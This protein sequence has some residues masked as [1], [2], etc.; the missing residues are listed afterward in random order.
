MSTLHS[1]PPTTTAGHHSHPVGFNDQAFFDPFFPSSPKDEQ[2]IPT[3]NDDSPYQQSYSN[4][5]PSPPQLLNSVNGA[6]CNQFSL[7]QNYSVPQPSSE[8]AHT[9]HFQPAHPPQSDVDHEGASVAFDLLSPSAYL[10]E[11]G[12]STASEFTA[13]PDLGT[14]SFFLENEYGVLEAPGHGI[15]L[16]NPSSLLN[17]HHRGDVTDKL[18]KRLEYSQHPRSTGGTAKFSSHLMSPVLTE[19]GGSSSRCGTNSP[20]E[21]VNCVKTEIQEDGT[22]DSSM[23]DAHLRGTD[24]SGGTMQ[25]TPAFTEGS[26]GTSSASSSVAPTLARAPS[27]IIRVD[28]YSR[29]DS[30]A[31]GVA[32]LPR[33]GGKRSRAGSHTSH[34]TVHQDDAS[35]EEEDGANHPDGAQGSTIRPSNR[36]GLDP[37]ARSQINDKEIPSLKDQ[38][39]HEQVFLKTIDVVEWLNRSTPGGENIAN[40]PPP[41][42]AAKSKRQRAKSTGAQTL[43]HAN[44]ESFE[45][46]KADSHIPGPGVLINEESGGE[47]D[48]D[49][50]DLASIEDSPP[51][52]TALGEAMNDTPGTAEPGVYDELSNQPPLYRAKLWQDP[53]YDSS[54]PGVK[55]QPVSANEAIKRY[56]ERA[57]DIETLSRVA[58]WG[59]RRM[60]ES[61]LNSLFHRLSVSDKPV[62]AAKEKRERRGSFLQQLSDRLGSRKGQTDAQRQDSG[63]SART[64]DRPTRPVPIEHYRNDSGGSR[65]DVLGVP[66]ASTSSLKKMPSL[67]KR[68]KSPRINTGSAVAAMALQAGALGAGGSVSAT[69][70]SPPTSWPKNV[71]KRP[72]SRSE[73]KNLGLPNSASSSSIEL[74][75]KGLAAMWT[76]QGGPPMPALAT[77]LKNE[78]TFNSVEEGED[79]EEEDLPEDKGIT[80]DLS[81]RSDPIEP[82]LEGFKANIRQLNPRLPPFMFDRIA[83]DQLRR[84]KKLMDFKVKHLQAL[85]VRKCASGKHCTELG[86]EPT[87]LPSRLGNR[88][89][90]FVHSGFPVA[91]LGQSDEDMGALTEGT[92][93][94]AQFPPGVPMPPVKR[95][96]AEFE[97]SLC[98]KVK[99]FHKPSDWSKHVHEDVQPFTCTFA[100]CPEPKSFKR[101]A[102]WVRHEN[103]RHRQLEWWTCNMNECSHKC[104]RK[105]NFVQHLVREHKLPEP[106]VKTVRTGRP[107]VRGPSS[108]RARNRH[109]DDMEE[110]NDEIDQVWKLVDECRHDTTKN[111]KDEPCKFCGNICNSWK[112]LTVHLAKHMEQISMPILGIVRQMEVSP[113]TIISPIEQRIAFQQKSISPTV[114]SSFSQKG[115]PDTISSFGMPGQQIGESPGAFT[116]LQPQSDSCGNAV[117]AELRFNHNRPS[118]NTYPPPSNVQPL[119]SVYSQTSSGGPYA[120]EYSTYAGSSGPRFNPANPSTAFSYPQTSTPEEL[121]NGGIRAPIEKPQAYAYDHGN[122]FRY[123]PQQRQTYSNLVDGSVYQDASAPTSSYSQQATPPSSFPFQQHLEAPT[124]SYFQPP[125]SMSTQIPMQYH[126]SSQ[127]QGSAHANNNPELRNKSHYQGYAYGHE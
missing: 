27:P 98:Y 126:Q 52:T 83:Q 67:S 61:D 60:S 73:L 115:Q 122:G 11:Y 57:R 18:P 88:E 8:G 66:Q 59:T 99:K 1:T 114:Q 74:G 97:C 119:P 13:T 85:S 76:K 81:I 6:L 51:P 54:D 106:K 75:A 44:L 29:G 10:S 69:G 47:D 124:S 79:K 116:T 4:H 26:K 15:G 109:G 38:E 34:L 45:A 123:L 82:T 50:D 24:L 41:K 120:S 68:P 22:A 35:E 77:P 12:Y 39:E 46:N 64:K 63:K 104:Y 71:M 20:P 103:E 111:P 17:S 28:G 58:T 118:P 19:T 16:N 21:G 113:E 72:R 91:G 94:P 105:D 84:F 89:A 48:Y 40:A 92:V 80:M 86:G 37:M 117:V 100:T 32:S 96:P 62:G 87:Y 23:Q 65:N 70:T 101:K 121:Y 56:H 33:G 43:S 31:R 2:L 112:K 107:A 14:N 42:P 5:T 95:L 30:P 36:S 125:V 55:L 90:E 102:D 9:D 25:M 7:A 110:S 127:M 3:E 78:D 108:Q 49:E 53:L 93:T